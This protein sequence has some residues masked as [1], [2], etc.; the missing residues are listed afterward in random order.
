MIDPI[1]KCSCISVL[2]FIAIY[3]HGL[4]KDCAPLSLQ[5]KLPEEPTPVVMNFIFNGD[6]G[7]F[8][9]V[10]GEDAQSFAFNPADSNSELTVLT[11]EALNT[12]ENPLKRF[13][14]E[15][16]LQ[17]FDESQGDE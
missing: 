13:F 8:I 9:S 4:G 12:D 17:E 15:D 7:N 3:Q 11:G 6:V 10:G 1:S 16:Y 2:D 5:A 14:I